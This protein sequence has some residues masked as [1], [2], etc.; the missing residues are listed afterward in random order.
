[1]FDFEKH[2]KEVDARRA[3]CVDRFNPSTRANYSSGYIGGK[4]YG[5][6]AIGYAY[7]PSPSR[8]SYFSKSGAGHYDGGGNWVED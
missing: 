4:A 1:M 6:S 3:V 7:S 5:N 2:N 8:S